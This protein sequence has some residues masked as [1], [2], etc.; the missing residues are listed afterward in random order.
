[1]A[2]G[3]GLVVLAAF[4]ATLGSAGATSSAAVAGPVVPA[5]NQAADFAG[6]KG[7]F[8]PVTRATLTLATFVAPINCTSSPPNESTYYIGLDTGNTASYVAIEEG[9]AGTTPLYFA[10]IVTDGTNQD[11]NSLFMSAG[12]KVT[13]LVSI[14]ATAELLK[15]VDRTS[16]QSLSYGGDGFSATGVEIM[17]RGEGQG[18]FPP[19]SKVRFSRIKVNKAAF[20]TI[21]PTAYN[22]VDP[23]GNTELTTTRLSKTGRAFTIRYL[24][25][26]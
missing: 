13:I 18:G 2:Y 19:F 23:S 11:P 17:Y 25:N 4:A 6:Y 14:G 15:I 20:S 3:R 12:D 10:G 26:V 5:K 21:T 1:M 16:E 8:S 9:C 24:S 7:S 22:Q